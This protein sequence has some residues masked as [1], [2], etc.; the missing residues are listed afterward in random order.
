MLVFCIIIQH[1]CTA[2]AAINN[3]VGNTG[4]AVLLNRASGGTGRTPAVHA[5]A[6]TLRIRRVVGVVESRWPLWRCCRARTHQRLLI[7][8]NRDM[9]SDQL[10]PMTTQHVARA[11]TCV[12]NP[13]TNRAG[14]L[15]YSV[16]LIGKSTSYLLAAFPAGAR[17]SNS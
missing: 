5:C 15:S 12:K 13:T 9:M 17:A 2:T 4:R 6:H 10:R 7:P 1:I 3:M 8:W 14:C 11:R 16:W